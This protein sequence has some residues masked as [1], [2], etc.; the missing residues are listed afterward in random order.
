MSSGFKILSIYLFIIYL[1]PTYQNQSMEYRLLLKSYKKL[2]CKT[3]IKD[4][5]E[6][7]FYEAEGK[8]LK[9]LRQSYFSSST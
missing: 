3:R 8:N 9:K 7:V 5:K 6:I 2:L 4:T 1:N